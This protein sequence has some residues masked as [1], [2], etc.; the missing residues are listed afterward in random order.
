M[1]WE[2]LHGAWKSQGFFPYFLACLWGLVNSLFP[3]IWSQVAVGLED[4][5]KGSLD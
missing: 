2:K 3:E 4:G 1:N 5:I